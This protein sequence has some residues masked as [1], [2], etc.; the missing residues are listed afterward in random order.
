VVGVGGIGVIVGSA[1]GGFV[2]VFEGVVGTGEHPARMRRIRR[3]VPIIYMRIFAIPL[4]KRCIREMD[5]SHLE[6]VDGV[7]G[8]TRTSRL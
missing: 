3:A 8:E 2:G 5:L 1:G 6:E 4:S 7:N